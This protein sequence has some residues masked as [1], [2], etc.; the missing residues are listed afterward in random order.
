MTGVDRAA[1]RPRGDGSPIGR[2]PAVTRWGWR[3]APAYPDGD[4]ELELLVS[5]E[6][7]LL[8]VISSR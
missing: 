7:G 2:S 4:G 8:N 5:T 3:G 6:D 1:E